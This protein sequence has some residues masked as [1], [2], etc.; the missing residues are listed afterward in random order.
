MTLKQRQY[1]VTKHAAQRAMLRF[2]ITPEK[3]TEWANDLMRKAKYVCANGSNRLVYDNNGIQ[4]V[5]DGSSHYII[6]IHSELKT[7]FLRPT[8]E[9]EIRK[10]KREGTRQIRETERKLASVY[11][12]LSTKLA[13]YANAKN[14]NTRKSIGRGVKQAQVKAAELG[15]EI[16]RIEDEVKAKIMAIE[17]ISD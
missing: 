16:E 2:G 17:L 9:R 4:L 13:N 8:L 15:R 14:P 6:T 3:V 10:I 1:T 7:D 11:A 12:E 5:V